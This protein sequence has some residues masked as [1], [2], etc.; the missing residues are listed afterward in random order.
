VSIEEAETQNNGDQRSPRAH[1]GRDDTFP[2]TLDALRLDPLQARLLA[3]FFADLW[4][5]F[6]HYADRVAHATADAAARR[7]AIA[8]CQAGRPAADDPHA[9]I[10]AW[11]AENAQRRRRRAM[12][13]RHSRILLLRLAGASTRRIS[14][15]TGLSLG[16]VHQV[17]AAARQ[18]LADRAGAGPRN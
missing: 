8:R 9:M 3:G 11:S 17:L 15:A 16:R 5:R 7:A 1:P 6:D 18:S 10:D 12:R 2:F 13:E 4:R 14:A